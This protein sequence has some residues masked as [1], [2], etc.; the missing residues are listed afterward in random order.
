MYIQTNISLEDHETINDDIVVQNRIHDLTKE[1]NMLKDN[2]ARN[3][4]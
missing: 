2:Y 1:N 4:K 3:Y